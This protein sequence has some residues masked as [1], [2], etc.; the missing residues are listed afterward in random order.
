[1][2]AHRFSLTLTLV[3][4]LA[5]GLV[6]GLYLLPTL[7]LQKMEP[8]IDDLTKR[9]ELILKTRA[10][11]AQIA[12]GLLLLLTLL[13]GLYR[14]EVAQRRNAIA[15]KDQVTDRF[16]R[17][18]EQLGNHNDF[19]RLAGVYAFGR[20]AKDD[21]DE[22][23]TVQRILWAFVRGRAD[24]ESSLV[25]DSDETPN[26]VTGDVQAAMDVLFRLGDLSPA[27]GLDVSGLILPK[28]NLTGARLHEITFENCLLT[29]AKFAGMTGKQVSFFNAQ[30]TGADFRN[31]K[32]EAPD[33]RLSNL[34]NSSFLNA[35]IT[36]G[37]FGK[38]KLPGSDLTKSTFRQCDFE[39]ATLT[40][41]K[42][43][44]ANLQNSN[45]LQAVLTEANFRRAD[46]QNATLI[47]ADIE[48]AVFT[49]AELSDC[50]LEDTD[51]EKATG[52]TLKD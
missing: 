33:F 47:R 23:A 46:L 1:M 20:I 32:I 40:K 5:A 16:L 37:R 2:S 35:H 14:I 6:A 9:H 27:K 11:Y 52:I 48:G 13:A 39:Q 50:D 3:T 41:A 38:T 29:G 17:A 21:P 30:L 24:K 25:T 22:L 12:G 51:L 49:E 8:A 7:E 34:S 18:S 31:S 15:Q 43:V 26:I 45:F 36:R 10:V 4:V 28:L 44:E 19:V 42:L